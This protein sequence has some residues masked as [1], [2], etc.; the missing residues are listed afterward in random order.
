MKTQILQKRQITNQK[1]HHFTRCRLEEVHFQENVGPSKAII[2]F[3][4]I[5]KFTGGYYT[6]LE[7]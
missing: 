5:R 4:I 2:T 6:Y 1:H 3:L 7:V